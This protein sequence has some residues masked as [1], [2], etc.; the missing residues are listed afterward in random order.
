M[1]LKNTVSRVFVPSLIFIY[2]LHVVLAMEGE[3]PGDNTSGKSASLTRSFSKQASS[4][5]RVFRKKSNKEST[6]DSDSKAVISK[7]SSVHS[8]KSGASSSSLGT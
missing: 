2:G 6:K 3:A 4:L 7:A 1:R 5:G 8:R